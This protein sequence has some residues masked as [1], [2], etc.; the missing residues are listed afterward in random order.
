VA[1]CEQGNPVPVK[2][3][4]ADDHAVLREGTRELLQADPQIEVVGEAADGPTTIALAAEL[5]PDVVLLDLA[6]PLINGIDVTRAIRSRP[7]APRVLVLS[8]YDDQDYVRSAIEAGAGGY[9][10]K[11]ATMREIIAAIHAV[12][13]GDIVLHPVMMTRLLAREDKPHI[14]NLTPREMEVMRLAVQG[15]HNKE[16]ASTLFLST[17][18]VEAHFTSIFNKLGVSSRTEAVVQGISNGWL[19]I[20]REPPTG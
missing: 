4:L 5:C 6:L 14:Q 16:I 2:V 15:V 13:R 19:V 17:R 18:T 9:L 20:R 11:V 8:A 1:H 3:L 7:D 12:S 10:T